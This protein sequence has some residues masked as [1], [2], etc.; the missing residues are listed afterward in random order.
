MSQT[1]TVIELVLRLL[2]QPG[3]SKLVEQYAAGQI[4]PEELRK[5]IEALPDPPPPKEQ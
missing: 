4:S 5:R 1:L 3:V 2:A